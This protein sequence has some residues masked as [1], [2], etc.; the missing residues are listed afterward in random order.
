MNEPPRVYAPY[1]PRFDWN[2]WFASL[3]DWRQ[4]N[5]VPLTEERLLSNEPDVLALFK[6]NPFPKAP[7][8]YVR[9]MLWQYWFT[10]IDEKRRTGN[11]WRRQLL[12]LY[13][14]EITSTG[15]GKFA[16]VQ[17][18]DELPPHN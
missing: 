5:I 6:S 18:P 2:L 4:N 14:P 15:E 8:R 3:G 16:I 1:Q 12:G 17:W 11:W 9:A 10:S 7:P 13:A